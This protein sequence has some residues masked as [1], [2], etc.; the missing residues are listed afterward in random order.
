MIFVG[1]ALF[2]GGNGWISDEA[3]WAD[4]EARAGQSAGVRNHHPAC[5]YPRGSWGPKEADVLIAANGCWHDSRANEAC[6]AAKGEA[7]K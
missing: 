3:P 4:N 7:V 2:P 6:I 1:D 5:P